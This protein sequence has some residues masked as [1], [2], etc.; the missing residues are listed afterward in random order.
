MHRVTR[1]FL[2]VVD[3]DRALIDR[4]SEPWMATQLCVCVC[5]QLSIQWADSSQGAM[6]APNA[7]WKRWKRTAEMCAKCIR[8]KPNEEIFRCRAYTII[9]TNCLRLAMCGAAYLWVCVCVWEPRF[10]VCE[11]NLRALMMS[12]FEYKLH[13][14]ISLGYLPCHP[15]SFSH[16]SV[17]MGTQLLNSPFRFFVRCSVGSFRSLAIACAPIFTPIILQFLLEQC[18][19]RF[20]LYNSTAVRPSSLIHS[21]SQS[22]SFGLRLAQSNGRI[23]QI[24][25]Y[26]RWNKT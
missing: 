18:V 5:V 15:S 12:T 23:Y 7:K 26:F 8:H 10:H 2:I 13:G 1:I 3:D 11:L 21:L 6:R 25:F 19:L 20:S 9:C 14:L 16:T 17:C 22:H 4:R 24:L